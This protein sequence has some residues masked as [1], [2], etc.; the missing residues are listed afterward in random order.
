VRKR[1]RRIKRLVIL[2]GIVGVVI[3]LRK[4]KAARDARTVLGPPAA[5]P[6]LKVG[7]PPVAAVGDLAAEPPVHHTSPPADVPLV[8]DVP[9]A[10]V[11]LLDTD[12]DI[13]AVVS[14]WVAPEGGSCPLSH[15]VKANTNSGIYHVPGGQFYERTRAERC[16]VDAAAAEADGYRAA[17]RTSG[18]EPDHG[19]QDTQSGGTT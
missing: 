12:P 9:V 7:E 4:A 13:D 2:G 10:A 6:P 19:I 8:A 15:P 16:Y 11:G 17:R 14:A 1:L 18:S 5:W 3:A